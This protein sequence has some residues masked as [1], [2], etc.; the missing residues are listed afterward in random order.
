MP[1]IVTTQPPSLYQQ[2]FDN[3]SSD[4]GEDRE[5]TCCDGIIIHIPTEHSLLFKLRCQ[6]HI[7]VAKCLA[8]ED[9]LTEAIE[10]LDKVTVV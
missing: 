5:V 9:H 8:D 4:Y 1:S 7:E 10:H 2:T 3:Y 6:V